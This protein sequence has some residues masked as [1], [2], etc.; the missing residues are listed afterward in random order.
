M[1]SLSR[2]ALAAAA[3]LVLAGCAVPTQTTRIGE[4]YANLAREAFR[5]IETA[6]SKAQSVAR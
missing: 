3:A 6:F 1:H 5:P 4:L 2:T